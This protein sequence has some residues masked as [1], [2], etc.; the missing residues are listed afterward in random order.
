[1]KKIII[2]RPVVVFGDRAR[3]VTT[4]LVFYSRHTHTPETCTIG[5]HRVRQYL[6]YDGRNALYTY[7]V[8]AHKYTKFTRLLIAAGFLFS[9]QIHIFQSAKIKLPTPT[10]GSYTTLVIHYYFNTRCRIGFL[11]RYSITMSLNSSALIVS[12]MVFFSINLS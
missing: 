1:M 4:F 10:A 8:H 6:M 7:V 9:C 5:K 3:L 12:S 2:R 11:S